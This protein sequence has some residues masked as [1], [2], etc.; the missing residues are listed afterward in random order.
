RS[1]PERALLVSVRIFNYS[2]GPI[3]DVSIRMDLWYGE[4]DPGPPDDHTRPPD[5]H[6]HESWISIPPGEERDAIFR[7]PRHGRVT[8]DQPELKFLDS[9]GRWFEKRSLQIEPHRILHQPRLAV[10]IVDGK[11]MVVEVPPESKF[12]ILARKLIRPR[13]GRKRILQ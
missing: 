11:P 12:R 1:S 2:N 13:W 9:A 6:A 5:D 10:R 8:V 7:L 4:T 3:L